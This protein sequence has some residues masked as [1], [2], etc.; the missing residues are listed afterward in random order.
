MQRTVDNGVGAEPFY[1]GIVPT[2]GGPREPRNSPAAGRWLT[3]SLDD[4]AAL[5]GRPV[6]WDYRMPGQPDV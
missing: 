3:G 4:L 1:P 5:T 6:R 2:I